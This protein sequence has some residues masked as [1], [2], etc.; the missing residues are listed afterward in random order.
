MKKSKDS[1]MT[2]VCCTWVDG[3]F[4]N[5]I[6]RKKIWQE[7]WDEFRFCCT[8]ISGS[9]I[10]KWYLDLDIAIWKLTFIL[11]FHCLISIYSNFSFPSVAPFEVIMLEQWTGFCKAFWVLYFTEHL[12]F[13]WML[14]HLR[15]FFHVNLFLILNVTWKYCEGHMFIWKLFNSV[16]LCHENVFQWFYSHPPFSPRLFEMFWLFSKC[17]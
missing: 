1:K 10:E 4:S 17:A 14:I 16:F 11:P 9:S 3:L 12:S 5:K 2:E 6:W 15:K 13:I 8:V 7:T